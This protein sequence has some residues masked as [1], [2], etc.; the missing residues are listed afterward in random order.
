[1]KL[2]NLLLIGSMAVMGAA[3]MSCSKDVA[4]DSEGLANQAAAQL[5]AE[6]RANFEKKYGAI[7]PNQTWDFSTMKPISLCL[8]LALLT[9]Q[10]R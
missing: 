5:K 2:R 6:Y 9:R 4:F 1:M 7:A 10:V 8:Q 3:F